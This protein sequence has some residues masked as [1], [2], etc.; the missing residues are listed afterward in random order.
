MKKLTIAA[1]AVL[2]AAVVVGV[3]QGMTLKKGTQEI[4]ASGSYDPDDVDNYSA[5]LTL[6]YGRFIA[7]NFEVGIRGTY[8]A[9]E[10]VKLFGVQGLAEYDFPVADKV[11]LFVQGTLGWLG[12]RFNPDVGDTQNNDTAAASAAAGAKYF[13]TDSV[14]LALDLEYTKAADDVFVNDSEGELV[15]N[16]TQ[17]NLSL[18]FYI[19]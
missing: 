18:R 14:A 6:G 19:P 12:G 1:M 16:N 8:G 15:D 3:A 11:N 13:I 17:F 2:A 5:D 7:D 9:T 10:H 4:Q